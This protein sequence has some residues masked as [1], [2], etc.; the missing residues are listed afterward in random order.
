MSYQVLARKWR[1]KRF[2]E[3]VGQ[4]HVLKAL[5]NALDDDRLHHAYL[6]TGTRGVGKTSIARLFAKSLNCET[7]VSSSPCGECSACREIAEG[8]FVDLIEV[9]AASRTKVED[10]RELLENV[11]YAPTHGR[12]KVYLIDEVHMLSTHSFNALLKTLEEPPPH[13]KFLLATT[14]P[15]KLPVTILSRCLQFNLK[16]M[17]PERIVDHLKFVLGEEAVPYEEPALWLLARSADGSMRDAMSLTDQAIAFGAGEINEAD[18]RAMLGTI[19]QRLVYRMLECLV[20]QDAQGLLDA[21]RDLA[22]FSPDYNT[23]LGDLISLLHRIAVGQALPSAVDNSM[24]DKELVQELAGRLRAE[25]LQLFYQIALM[26]RKDL[27]FVPDAREGLEMVLLRMLAFRPAGAAPSGPPA[28]LDSATSATLPAESVQP[29][30]PVTA[31]QPPSPIA[32]PAP[33]PAVE[34]KPE[35]EPIQ[36]PEPNAQPQPQPVQQAPA[37][38]A[39]APVMPNTAPDMAPAPPVHSMDDIPPWED[40]DIPADDYAGGHQDLPSGAPETPPGKKS[41]PEL[42]AAPR[43]AASAPVPAIAAE[44][45]PNVVQSAAEVPAQNL[46]IAQDLGD[47]PTQLVDLKE[48]HW[49][50]LATSI[51][52]AGMTASLANNLSLEQVSDATL[53]FHYTPEQ[54]TLLNDV[55]RNRIT[56]ALNNYFA[57]LVEVEF[58]QDTQS[59]ETPSL[60]QIRKRKERLALAVE[61][62]QNDETVHRLQEHFDAEI[63]LASVE[64]ID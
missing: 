59:R 19:D 40:A 29:V 4:E 7:G 2:Q 13:V 57:V 36:R 49:A 3:M 23:V 26:G 25:D 24:G 54:K 22:Q 42:I 16:N 17:I 43:E 58:K 31:A 27:P 33:A 52:L 8:R 39:P 60:Y 38:Q 15:Q 28:K 50:R 5:V 12:Y 9:D 32:A 51:G 37:P 21:V 14:D 35:P 62:I 41:E 10:T 47:L 18:A 48:D 61:S 44:A 63:D 56:D 20:E 55:Q 34:A 45:A 11:Q 30:A 64:P 53:V 1:P 46:K 6:F